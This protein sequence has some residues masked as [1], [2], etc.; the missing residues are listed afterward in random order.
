[1]LDRRCFALLDIV[2][3][4][5]QNSGYKVIEIADLVTMMPKE[6]GCD[7]ENL[8]ECIS[9]LSER[10]YI[11]VKYEDEKEICLSPLPKGRMVFENKKETES[12]ETS[13]KRS[14]FL[15]GFLGAFTGSLIM[16]LITVIIFFLGGLI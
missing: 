14:Y 9:A 3:S 11:S 10:E 6:F 16:T 7:K 2:N 13:L 5:C 8:R 4:Q 12:N 15:F 1:M